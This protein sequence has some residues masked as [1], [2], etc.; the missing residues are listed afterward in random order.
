LP[1][2]TVATN[3][4]QEITMRAAVIAVGSIGREA[5]NSI[6]A[7]LK[8]LTHSD[9]SKQR[10]LID[11]YEVAWALD[12]MRPDSDKIL[13]GMLSSTNAIERES[14]LLVLAKSPS[15]TLV[16]AGRGSNPHTPR[17]GPQDNIAPR[18]ALSKPS[19]S[20]VSGAQFKTAI[21]QWLNDSDPRIRRLAEDALKNFETAS[22]QSQRA[23]QA[24]DPAKRAAAVAA[25]GHTVIYKKVEST[26]P[27]Q[28]D[29][30]T[31][32]TITN[33]AYRFKSPEEATASQEE[34]LLLVRAMA[35]PDL[36]ARS[37]AA[38]CV[39]RYLG[40]Y[41]SGE[42]SAVGRT[43]G[44][45][46]GGVDLQIIHAALSDAASTG[47]SNHLFRVLMSVRRLGPAAGPLLPALTNAVQNPDPQMRWWMVE[48]LSRLSTRAAPAL[49]TLMVTLQDSDHRVRRESVEALSRIGAPATN[50]VPLLIK[51]L[52]SD[53]ES[54]VRLSAA[55][56][57]GRI[58]PPA[59]EA[60][61]ALRKALL[62]DTGV[63]QTQAKS[64]LEALQGPT[65]RGTGEPVRKNPPQGMRYEGEKLLV[66]D[67][68]DCERAS[69]QPMTPWGETNW[70][71]G[72]Q[73]FCATGAK[74]AVT[75][76]LSIPKSGTFGMVLGLTRAPDYGQ[77][78][79]LLDDRKVFASLDG[80]AREV[81]APRAIF[82]GQLDLKS[83]KHTIRFEVA[84]K[85]AQSKGYF[86]GI[87][88]IEFRDAA[89]A[90]AQ[91]AP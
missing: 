61:P 26:R 22:E 83:G 2:L 8:L 50:A 65:M 44:A 3:A 40:Q 48:A 13:L 55:Y 88:F 76:E 6:P 57:L 15:L 72:A 1:L 37:T 9:A 86:M 16:E 39:V 59:L 68:Q 21:L 28:E 74:G 14:S 67:K 78:G 71:G 18:P 82:L 73:L 47:Q 84:G 33:T 53:P 56:A 35:D 66:L 23:L 46:V 12:R 17:P 70:S 10:V 79:V 5:T 11:K 41:H 7:L 52:Q 89:P 87:D 24:K 75:V 81:S 58:K 43:N 4:G 34:L 69:N 30:K 36:E 91:P 85:N 45:S 80:Y 31:I 51:T 27:V 63:V 77:I 64:A 19:Q 90:G 54:N 62:E 49:P 60:I 38:F 20:P 25:L 42:L 32:L 29:G